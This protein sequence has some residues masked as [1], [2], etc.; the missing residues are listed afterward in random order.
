MTRDVK[1]WTIFGTHFI[2]CI[3][4]GVANLGAGLACMDDGCP[5]QPDRAIL[6][7]SVASAWILMLP[8]SILFHLIPAFNPWLLLV[9]IPLN[10]I[11]Y[12]KLT[13]IATDWIDEKRQVFKLNKVAVLD[14]TRDRE[15]PS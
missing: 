4:S 5:A 9:L 12:T 3:V 7:A 15:P 14:E 6:I 10:S 13:M 11:L 2:L 8:V 1:F